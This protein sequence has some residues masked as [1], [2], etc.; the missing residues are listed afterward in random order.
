MDEK[1]RVVVFEA[2]TA[3]VRELERAWTHVNRQINALILQKNQKSVEISTKLLALIYCAL[4]ESIFS[5]IYIF[6]D[7]S[8]LFI[9][10]AT[11]ICGVAALTQ[12]QRRRQCVLL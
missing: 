4:A 5:S 9:Y 6:V 1:Q 8:L 2:Q 11:I 10:Y 7:L 3:N 12:A